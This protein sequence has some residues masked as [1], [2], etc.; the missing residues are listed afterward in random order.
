[1]ILIESVGATLAVARRYA[2][3]RP[4]GPPLQHIFDFFWNPLPFFSSS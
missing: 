2:D 3:G 4:Q 1:M